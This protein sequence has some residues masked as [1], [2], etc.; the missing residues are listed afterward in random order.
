[1]KIGFSTLA[2]FMS[3]FKDIFDVVVE[4]GFDIVEILCEG[5]YLPRYLLENHDF[6]IFD[7]YDFDVFIHSPSIDLNH[8]SMNQGI[9]EETEKQIFET[10]D[11]ARKMNAK[12]ITIHPGLIHR[13]EKRTRDMAVEYALESIKKCSD[14]AKEI[15]IILSLENMP[16]KVNFLCNTPEEHKMFVEECECSATIDLGHANTTGRVEDFLKL[17]NI[18]Y[19]HL[20]DNDGVKDQHVALGEGTLDLNLLKYVD[21]GIIELNTYEKVRKSQKLIEGVLANQ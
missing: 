18:A 17:D 2:L 1:M 6:E 12:V 21:Y 8:A 13:I 7:S 14:Y 9:R 4:D 15:D 20:N 3:S 19:Y 5:P 10:L 16:N 11:V